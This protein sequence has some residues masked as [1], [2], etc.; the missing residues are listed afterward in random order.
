MYEDWGLIP[1]PLRK[2]NGYRIF[3]NV[4]I[5]QFSLVHTAFQIAIVHSGLR[6]KIIQVVKLSANGEYENAIALTKVYV[7]NVNLGLTNRNTES[8]N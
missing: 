4:H 8:T 7:D 5:D 1:K 6:K 2:A 3:S